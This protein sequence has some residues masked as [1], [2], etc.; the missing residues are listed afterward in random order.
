MSFTD[1]RQ[2]MIDALN[3]IDGINAFDDQPRAMRAGSAWVL[4][5]LGERGPG[6][7][8]SGEWRVVIVLGGDHGA[9]VDRLDELLPK[10]IAEFRRTGAGYAHRVQPAT[11]RTDRGDMPA[12]ELYVRSE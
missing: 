4:F 11:V 3:R 10:I 12:V 1:A 6:A 7:A 9:A 5:D 8:W 2:R